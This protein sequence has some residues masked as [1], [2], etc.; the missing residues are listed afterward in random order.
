M[1]IRS[2]PT[3][4]SRPPWGES[5]EETQEENCIFS[6][7]TNWG[8]FFFLFYFQLMLLLTFWETPL[9][10]ISVFPLLSPDLFWL[11]ITWKTNSAH[12]SVGK[13]P[14]GLCRD[15]RKLFFSCQV[16]VTRG[17][18]SHSRLCPFLSPSSHGHLHLSSPGQGSCS[19]FQH[20]RTSSFPAET[21][22]LAVGSTRSECWVGTSDLS[23]GLSIMAAA[24]LLAVTWRV[25]ERAWGNE[26]LPQAPD[27]LSGSVNQYPREKIPCLLIA[28]V[29]KIAWNSFILLLKN[30]TTDYAYER[31]QKIMG[32]SD[33]TATFGLFSVSSGQKESNQKCPSKTPHQLIL[34]RGLS[35]LPGLRENVATWCWDGHLSSSAT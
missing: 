35:G 15:T 17:R 28:E 29:W 7:N 5:M 34:S 27:C 14:E 10:N 13:V 18:I 4:Y 3:P 23:K 32:N 16:P 22:D 1:K 9:L 21:G 33:E 19:L 11:Q 6:Q 31:V 25:S 30:L 8:F 24:C 12:H 26:F 20:W 2:R